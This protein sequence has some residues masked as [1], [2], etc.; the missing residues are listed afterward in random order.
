MRDHE[1]YVAIVEHR[2]GR[3]EQTISA[4]ILSDTVFQAADRVF[5]CRLF[6]SWYRYVALNEHL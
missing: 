5:Y 2:N 6:P 3:T 1:L 4:G